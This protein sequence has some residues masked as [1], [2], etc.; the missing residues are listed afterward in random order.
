[1]VLKNDIDVWSKLLQT[2]SAG[3]LAI[4]KYF[5]RRALNDSKQSQHQSTLSTSSSSYDSNFLSW[6]DNQADIFQDALLLRPILKRIILKNYFPI[7]ENFFAVVD[8]FEFTIFNPVIFE[9]VGIACL[10]LQ[11]S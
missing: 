4:N 7:I 6:F 3:I 11:S 8:L 2:K 1:M 10:W 5:A 9:I